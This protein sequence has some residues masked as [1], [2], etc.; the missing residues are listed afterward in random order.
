MRWLKWLL[1]LMMGSVAALVGLW[2]VAATM[3]KSPDQVHHRSGQTDFD[4][5]GTHAAGDGTS[6]PYRY[7]YGYVEFDG[8]GNYAAPAQVESLLKDLTASTA[9]ADTV[10][11]LFVH[12]WN[13]DARTGDTNVACFEELVK[14]TAIMQA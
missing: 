12:G 5:S 14:A 3:F 8:L 13:H 7:S 11:L 2:I 1:A 6:L 10:I 9:R 4:K